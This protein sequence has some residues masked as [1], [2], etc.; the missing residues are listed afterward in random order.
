MGEP[1]FGA[2]AYGI[3]IGPKSRAGWIAIVAYLVLMATIPIACRSLTWPDWTIP[4]ALGLLTAGLLLLMN[5][6][7]DGEPWR[8]RW[9]GR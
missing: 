2:K 7:S 9:G 4:I 5:L 3:G 6:K 8:W 1:W